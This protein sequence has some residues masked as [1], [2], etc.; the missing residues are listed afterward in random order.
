MEV[1]PS[2]RC[3]AIRFKHERKSV[4]YQFENDSQQLGVTT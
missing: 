4:V 3:G 1:N 2:L